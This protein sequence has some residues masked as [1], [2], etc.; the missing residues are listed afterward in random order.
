VDT[1]WNVI[2]NGTPAALLVS[3]D[4]AAV[5]S[6]G[7]PGPNGIQLYTV[8]L[9]TPGTQTLTATD[10]A[11][12]N[13]LAP[14]TSANVVVGGGAATHFVVNLPAA[15]TAGATI[16]GS[17]TA[18]DASGNVASGY[19]GLVHLSSTD[20]AAVFPW[21][22]A[23]NNGVG[24]F[25]FTFKNAGGQTVMAADTLTPS[26]S[27]TSGVVAVGPAPATNLVVTLP[28][29]ATAGI[30]FTGIVT[31]QDVFGNAAAGYAG[32]VSFA[33]SDP[34]AV[35]PVN[36]QL[37]NGTGTFSF[38]LKTAGAQTVSVKDTAAAYL[39]TTPA[40]VVV[41][42]GAAASLAASLPGSA[43]AGIPLTGTVTAQ[44]SFGNNTT[45]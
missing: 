3:S 7:G 17:I 45:N 11:L 39:S 37:T 30:S 40:P 34:A 8:T 9:N 1:N 31:A 15:A 16:S 26:I 6:A 10:P 29:T 28:A 20:P 38:T 42:P 27:G 4:A 35:I 2:P 25:N 14:N 21:K 5:I 33:C 18:R 44:D 12:L 43:V 24:V 13:P 22:T 32:T 23:L 19:T 36:S 41:A